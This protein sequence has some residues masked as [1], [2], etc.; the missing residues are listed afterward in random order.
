MTFLLVT[1]KNFYNQAKISLQWQMMLLYFTHQQSTAVSA[2]KKK[3]EK[4]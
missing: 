1:K 4:R 3:N 2:N